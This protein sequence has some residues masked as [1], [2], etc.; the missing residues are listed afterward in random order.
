[1]RHDVALDGFAFRLRPV[2]ADDAAYITAL[3][4]DPRL[5]RFINRTSPDV[6]AQRRWL[7]TYFATPADYYFIVERRADGA[8]E[9][10]LAISD[11]DG[12]ARRAEWGRWVLRHGS[13][14]AAE[15]AWL[16]Y[17]VAFERLGLDL[18][19]CRTIAANQRVVSFHAGCGLSTHATLAGRA[20]LDGVPHDL[21]EQHMT[22]AAWSTCGPR[23]GAQAERAAA[24]VAR[25]SR[26]APA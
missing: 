1:M 18:L 15:S 14:A 25:S 10:T 12:A 19:Y 11:V 6:D 21:V 24:L 26:P 4:T 9:G 13:L 20:V 17:R 22:H 2:T 16:V 8:P 3:R 5:A 7:E 23:L